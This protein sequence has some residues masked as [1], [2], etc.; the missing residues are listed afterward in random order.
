MLTEHDMGQ[1]THAELED[2]TSVS[3]SGWIIT[4]S[5]RDKSIP[6][7]FYFALCIFFG[8]ES[9]SEPTFLHNRYFI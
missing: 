1:I 9:F 7:S 2:E 4:D 5:V 8:S 6:V 3:V